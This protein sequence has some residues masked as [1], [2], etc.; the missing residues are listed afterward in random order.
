MT[1]VS[2]YVSEYCVWLAL[3]SGF[4]ELTNDEQFPFS[5]VDLNT[6]GIAVSGTHLLSPTNQQYC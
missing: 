3:R 2:D 1:V 5:I 4:E 6:T